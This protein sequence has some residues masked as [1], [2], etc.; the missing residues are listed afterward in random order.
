MEHKLQYEIIQKAWEKEVTEEV[1]AARKETLACMN[2]GLKK[3]ETIVESLKKDREQILMYMEESGATKQDIENHETSLKQTDMDISY[4]ER[5]YDVLKGFI[6][7]YQE[8]WNEVQ[9]SE[10][11]QKA[12]KRWMLESMLFLVTD[13]NSSCEDFGFPILG[14]I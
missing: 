11:E 4:G 9:L 7:C 13:E 14:T 6:Q 10:E 3:V 5:L 2:I 12:R 8:I 1:E